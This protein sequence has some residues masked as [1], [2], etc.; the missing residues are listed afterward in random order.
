MISASL[1]DRVP[2]VVARKYT[3]MVIPAKMV[4]RSET[5]PRRVRV[6]PPVMGFAA[7]NPSYGVVTLRYAGG[8]PG[9]THMKEPM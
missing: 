7:L 2:R 6:A 1:I 3:V 9:S 8:K 5:Y 4:E